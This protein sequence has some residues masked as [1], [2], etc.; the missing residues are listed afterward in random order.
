[1][2][3]AMRVP[4]D[5]ALYEICTIVGRSVRGA[6]DLDA[7]NVR[8]STHLVTEGRVSWLSGRSEAQLEVLPPILLVDV[9]GA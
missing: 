1:M 9:Y 8:L 2:R 3:A 6:C 4:G 7:L 5:E